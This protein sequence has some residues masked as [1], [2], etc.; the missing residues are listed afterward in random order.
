M[1]CGC[2]DVYRCGRYG[3]LRAVR[4]GTESAT[5]QWLFIQKERLV[6]TISIHNTAIDIDTVVV[7][8][9]F[10][11]IYKVKH[12]QSIVVS[13]N[14]QF[15]VRLKKRYPSQNSKHQLLPAIKSSKQKVVENI[16]YDVIDTQRDSESIHSRL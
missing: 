16:V 9:L 15:S 1:A 2:F 10:D 12:S 3:I 13:I 5:T 14:H 8:E 7:I 4:T 6:H 11:L